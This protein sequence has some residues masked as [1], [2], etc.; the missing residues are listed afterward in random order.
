MASASPRRLY[1][2][3]RPLAKSGAAVCAQDGQ[4]SLVLLPEAL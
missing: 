4:K 3:R 1:L 2:P